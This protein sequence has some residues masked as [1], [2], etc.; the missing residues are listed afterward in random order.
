M[1]YMLICGVVMCGLLAIDL[2]TKAVAEVYL[3]GS[4]TIIPNFIGLR[5]TQNTGIAWGMFSDTKVMMT[6]ITI[7]TAFMI[8]GIGV[9]FFT[10]FKKN[11]PAQMCLAIIEAGAIGNL[12]DRLCLGYVRDFVDVSKIGFGICNLADF[13]ITFSAVV[14]VI[15]ILFIGK[16]A[17]IPLGKWKKEREREELAKQTENEDHG[18]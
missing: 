11:R 12:V 15:I 7:L 14:L 5:F 10:V 8:L 18:A 3:S 2:V 4:V 9:L 13:F 16:D 6:I 1:I 17:V